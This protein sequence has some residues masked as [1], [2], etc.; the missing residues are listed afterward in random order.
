LAVSSACPRVETPLW[1]GLMVTLVM[2]YRRHRSPRCRLGIL[3][4]LGRRSQNADYPADL[5]V[6]FIEVIRGV[7]LITVLFMASDHA[8][9]VRAARG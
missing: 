2:S 3:L 5:S 7:P 6:T 4:A 1:G 8:A 9:A